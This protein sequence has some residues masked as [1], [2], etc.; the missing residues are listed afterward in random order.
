MQGYDLA[1]ELEAALRDAAV[2][3]EATADPPPASAAVVAVF[4]Q[5]VHVWQVADLDDARHC[6]AAATARARQVSYPPNWL[7][8][9]HAHH[10]TGTR[11]HTFEAELRVSLRT[12]PERHTAALLTWQRQARTA[13]LS[14]QAEHRACRS[15]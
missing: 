11:H 6:S 5:L 14:T 2:A 9:R 12:A 10:L 15:S 3:C 8:E 4:Q 13:S 7:P 1:P